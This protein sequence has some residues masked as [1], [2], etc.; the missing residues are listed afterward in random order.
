VL[1]LISVILTFIAGFIPSRIA[2]K[3]DPVAALRSE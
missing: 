3:K 1:I 2:A